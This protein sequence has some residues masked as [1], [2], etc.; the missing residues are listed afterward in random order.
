MS[1]V[2]RQVQ[3]VMGTRVPDPGLNLGFLNLK[4]GSQISNFLDFEA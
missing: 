2:I 1:I 3:L 4:T